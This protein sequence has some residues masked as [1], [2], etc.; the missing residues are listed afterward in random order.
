MLFVNAIGVKCY[1][2]VLKLM[3]HSTKLLTF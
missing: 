3:Q 1:L 2:I